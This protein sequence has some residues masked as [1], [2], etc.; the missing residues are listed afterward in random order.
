MCVCCH[1][2]VSMNSPAG[3]FFF[4]FSQTGPVQ[5]VTGTK[6]GVTERKERGREVEKKRKKNKRKSPNVS[7]T[8]EGNERSERLKAKGRERTKDEPGG[9]GSQGGGRQVRG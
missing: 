5:P 1:S 2:D 8:K 4:F 7:K 3:V 9:G 6:D